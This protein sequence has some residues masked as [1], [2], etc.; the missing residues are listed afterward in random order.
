KMVY[1]GKNKTAI[2]YEMVNTVKGEE[3]LDCDRLD[4][5]FFDKDKI[6]KITALGNVY[7]ESPGLENTEGVGTLL[8]WDFSENL[9][10][11]TGDPLAELRRSGARTFSEKIYF[12]MNSKRVHWEGKPHWQIYAEQ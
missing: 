9:A 1:N 7:I 2:F 4:V 8:V 3:K 5:L 10:V 11:L 12:D 6:K